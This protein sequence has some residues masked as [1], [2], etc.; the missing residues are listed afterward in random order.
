MPDSHLRPES[1]YLKMGSRWVCSTWLCFY[2][3]TFTFTGTVSLGSALV[4]S[5]CKSRS[6]FLTSFSPCEITSGSPGSSAS[7]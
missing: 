2:L 7:G 4:K 3:H 6:K 5:G 1:E